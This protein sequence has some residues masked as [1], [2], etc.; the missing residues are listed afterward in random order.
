MKFAVNRDLEKKV[1]RSDQAI[2]DYIAM[3]D[4]SD[5]ELVITDPVEGYHVCYADDNPK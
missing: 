4:G 5:P 1:G 3:N 2:K